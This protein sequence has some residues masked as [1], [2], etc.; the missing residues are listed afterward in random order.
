MS[1]S[2]LRILVTGASRG[3]GL[4]LVRQYLATGAQVFAAARHPDGELA[5]L[6]TAHAA[7]LTLIPLDV[8]LDDQRQAAVATVEKVA[9]ALDVLVNNAGK[10]AK[11]AALGAYTDALLL[12]LVHTNAVAPVMLGQAFLPLLARGTNPRLVNVSTQVGSFGWN[13]AGTSAPYAAS[14]AALNMY[15]R[16]LARE[17]RGI[18]TIAVHPGWVKTDMGGPSATL[19]VVESATYLRTLV[20]RLEPSDSGQF[21]N[22]DGTPHPW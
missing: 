20:D 18:T 19:T 6:A 12:E 7:T 3:L 5:A 13:Q 16:A 15:T 17:A 2:K 14:K 8:T 22:Y 21:F 10:N 11:G 4:E 1:P 9:G